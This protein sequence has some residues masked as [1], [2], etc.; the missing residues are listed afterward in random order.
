MIINTED[1]NE[2]ELMNNSSIDDEQ[3]LKMDMNELIKN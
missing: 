2:A 3:M 1:D